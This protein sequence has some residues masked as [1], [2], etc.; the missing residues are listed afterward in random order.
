MN[1]QEKADL[2]DAK[3]RITLLEKK[4]DIAIRLLEEEGILRSSDIDEQL[5]KE[6]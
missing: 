6:I 3:T 4:L 2:I 5:D 1:E